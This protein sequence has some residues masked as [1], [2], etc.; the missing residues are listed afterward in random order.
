MQSIVSWRWWLRHAV[1]SSIVETLRFCDNQFTL[2]Y[3]A[4]LKR[5]DTSH[6]EQVCDKFSLDPLVER[7][8]AIERGRQID[9]KKPWIQLVIDEDVETEQLKAVVPER[10]ILLACIE[11]HILSREDS[12]D[13]HILNLFEN[14]NII[15]TLLSKRFP[16][17]L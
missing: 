3:F 7:G 17:S 5:S 14:G 12:L 11:Y 9:L 4:L 8:I 6:G 10:H 16:E 1:I 15:N 2:A 13:D